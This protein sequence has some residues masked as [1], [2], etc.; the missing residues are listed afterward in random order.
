MPT[1]GLTCCRRLGALHSDLMLK[2]HKLPLFYLP[3]HIHAPLEPRVPRIRRRR[4]QPP[5]CCSDSH[6]LAA[7]PRSRSAESQAAFRYLE[8]DW[9]SLLTGAKVMRGLPWQ[10]PRHTKLSPMPLQI[11]IA[12]KLEGRKNVTLK[13]MSSVHKGFFCI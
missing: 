2:L 5:V 8:N 1:E 10:R 4:K 3:Y 13:L 6:K 9:L 7:Y 12:H 11:N